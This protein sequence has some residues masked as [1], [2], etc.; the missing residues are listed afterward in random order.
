MVPG[1][2]IPGKH[3]FPSVVSIETQSCFPAHGRHGASQAEKWTP[4]HARSEPSVQVGM[5]ISGMVAARL[6]R[7]G[8]A[9]SFSTRSF[10]S[11]DSHLEA[12]QQ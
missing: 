2:G 8:D 10:F 1:A 6:K 12:E 3:S 11:K 4:C 7:L 5:V 9:V